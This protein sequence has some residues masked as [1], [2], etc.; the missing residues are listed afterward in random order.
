MA[1]D[2]DRT[3]LARWLSKQRT[4]IDIPGHVTVRE[5]MRARGAR[6][7]VAIDHLLS[8]PLEGH[9]GWRI[10]TK[11]TFLPRGHFSSYAA[12]SLKT[13]DHGRG[14]TIYC[15]DH[16]V[17]DEVVAGISY[18]IDERSTWPVFVTAIGF[19]IDFKGDVEL[20][21]RTVA[22]AYLLKQYV[23]AISDAAGRG[24]YVHIEVPS[25]DSERHARELGF[26]KAH[27]L[28]GLRTSGTHMRQRALGQDSGSGG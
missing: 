18:H 12:H 23:H 1:Q 4:T 26:H 6:T 11:R 14:R 7:I 25:N 15:Q 5:A 9:E 2:D 19:R 27:K 8:C 22:G 21:R 24:P 10:T 17:D 3:S 20:R 16:V 13:A 28:K